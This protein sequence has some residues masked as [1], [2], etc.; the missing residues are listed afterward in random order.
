[1]ISLPRTVFMVES[2]PSLFDRTTL[3]VLAAAAVVINTGI[4]KKAEFIM[5]NDKVV[6]RIP[7]AVTDLY[8]GGSSVDRAVSTEFT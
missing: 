8:G 5:E 6:N 3:A 1:M 4:S 2:E 7:E